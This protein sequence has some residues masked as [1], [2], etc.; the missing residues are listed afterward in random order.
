M[1]VKSFPADPTF[2]ENQMKL[3][4]QLLEWLNG[5]SSVK[6]EVQQS[7]AGKGDE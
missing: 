1:D 7:S 3:Q 6:V 2:V 4:A 5:Q